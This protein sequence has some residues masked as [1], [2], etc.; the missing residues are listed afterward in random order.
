MVIHMTGMFLPMENHEEVKVGDAVF[1]N[2]KGMTIEA[3]VIKKIGQ[4][5]KVTPEDRSGEIWFAPSELTKVVPGGAEELMSRAAR[6]AEKRA[7]E[8]AAAKAEA[9][10]KAAEKAENDYY[11]QMEKERENAITMALN[12][13]AVPAR[14][15]CPV[16][17]HCWV[18]SPI[19]MDQTKDLYRIVWYE[20]DVDKDYGGEHEPPKIDLSEVDE[21]VANVEA[22]E[23]EKKMLAKENA[24]KKKGKPKP[25]TPEQV[26][27][28]EQEQA[29]LEAKDKAEQDQ[30]RKRAEL[31]HGKAMDDYKKAENARTPVV[32]PK[33]PPDLPPELTP[34]EHPAN[35]KLYEKLLSLGHAGDRVFYTDGTMHNNPFVMGSTDGVLKG[36]GLCKE[37][38]E[39]LGFSE[40]IIKFKEAFDGGITLVKHDCFPPEDTAEWVYKDEEKWVGE[41]RVDQEGQ[42]TEAW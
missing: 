9:D 5:I 20:I 24:K 40:K 1:A 4:R 35:Q 33:Y 37:V 19:L 15:W 28:E 8:E 18:E 2:V 34:P 16:G 3:A 42:G 38:A 30:A 7:R 36:S 12:K 41:F 31:K 13:R 26:A 6:A 10:R 14:D 29:E 21:L 11:K 39:K 23:E 27:A 25:K 32:P 17:V 22:R